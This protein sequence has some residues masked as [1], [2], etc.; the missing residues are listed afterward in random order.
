MKKI[1]PN[2]MQVLDGILFDYM[3]VDAASCDSCGN[4]EQLI[5]EIRT[6]GTKGSALACRVGTLNS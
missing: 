5:D 1:Y 2:V 4:A 3:L 6:H